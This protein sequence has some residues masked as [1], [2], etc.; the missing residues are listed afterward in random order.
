MRLRFDRVL[1]V[2]LTGVIGALFRCLVLALRVPRITITGPGQ[3]EDD[4]AD[5]ELTHGLT[6]PFTAAVTRAGITPPQTVEVES[7]QWVPD[8]EHVTIDGATDT[9]TCEARGAVNGEGSLTFN[10]VRVS[11][12]LPI[13]KIVTVNVHSTAPEP[14]PDVVITK[15]EEG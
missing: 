3:G 13:T 8:G 7:I 11:D 6:A 9:L 10:A 14:A 12:S 15:G 1:I 2:V 5:F 4:M